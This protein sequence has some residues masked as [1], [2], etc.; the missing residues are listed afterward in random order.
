MTSQQFL[1]LK[2][3]VKCDNF[4]FKKEEYGEPTLQLQYMGYL[5]D[6]NTSQFL[7]EYSQYH[8]LNVEMGHL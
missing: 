1:Q 5:Q 3:R 2:F 6:H 4:K 7:S 8:K